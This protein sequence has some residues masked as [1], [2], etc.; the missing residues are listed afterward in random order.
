M[1]TNDRPLR[2]GDRVQQWRDGTTRYGVV[3]SVGWSGC[4]G[5]VLVIHFDD[6][7]DAVDPDLVVAGADLQA[8]R[9]ATAEPTAA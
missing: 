3:T 2:P 8:L 1:Y 6:R 7:P 5:D 9:L 4:L